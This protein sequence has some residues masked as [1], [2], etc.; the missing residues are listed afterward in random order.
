[1]EVPMSKS[2][3]PLAVAIGVFLAALTWQSPA[4]SAPPQA[5]SPE[6]QEKVFS[7]GQDGATAPRLVHRELPE[8]TAEARNER[9]QGTVVLNVIVG[10]D[11]RAHHIVVAK[12]L[13]FGLDEK[14]M[15]CV[16]QWRFE[17]GKKDGEP[18][19]VKAMI[20]MNFRP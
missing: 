8:Y 14:A 1:M 7:A 19:A 3:L 9:I 12:G 10:P 4:Q 18:V 5:N 11:D 13:G 20:E 15:E 2:G 6:S 16:Q 17:P